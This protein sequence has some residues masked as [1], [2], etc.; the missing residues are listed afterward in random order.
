MNRTLGGEADAL[1]DLEPLLWWDTAPATG[2]R[3]VIARSLSATYCLPDDPGHDHALL[4]GGFPVDV[5]HLTVA[6]IDA[7]LDSVLRDH[8]LDLTAH[9]RLDPIQ[10]AIRLRGD[11]LLTG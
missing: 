6:D 9:A 2:T 10:S 1:S 11:D 8:S 5:W 3:A 4:V 7:T